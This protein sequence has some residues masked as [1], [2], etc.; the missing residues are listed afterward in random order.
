MNVR[1]IIFFVAV[2]ALLLQVPVSCGVALSVSGRADREYAISEWKGK[3]YNQI[4][5]S[6]GA[7]DRTEPDGEDGLI[8]IYED[9]HEVFKTETD[10]HL[11]VLDP[12]SKTV[13]T[14][15]R[16]FVEFFIGKDNK[17]Y[18][19]RTNLSKS[20]LRNSEHRPW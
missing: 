11:G 2:A 6:F 1:K 14:T 20:Q 3:V 12:E 8:V 18:H 13:S 4:V 16:R 15:I 5:C 19:V 9:W 10:T 17:C 7:P